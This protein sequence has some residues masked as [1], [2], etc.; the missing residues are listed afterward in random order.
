[1]TKTL[2]LNLLVAL[3]MLGCASAKTGDTAQAGNAA[4]NA[5]NPAGTFFSSHPS[6][7]EQSDCVSFLR[8]RYKP[9]HESTHKTNEA[10]RFWRDE[11]GF[12]K[13][14]TT[15][16]CMRF[17]Y[18]VGQVM[19]E[20]YVVKP[21]QAAQHPLPVIIYNRGGN[22]ALS[23]INSDTL[24]DDFF[25]LA[26]QGFIVIG[27][28]YRGALIWPANINFDPG[29]DEFGGEDV[30]DVTALIPILEKMPDADPKRIGM[31]GISRGGMMTYMASKNNPKIKAIV[32][33]A[34]VTDHI[35][36]IPFRPVFDQRLYPRLIPNYATNKEQVLRDRSVLFWLDEINIKM[37][38]L[39]LHGDADTKV[40]VTNSIKL[41]E[42][43]KHRGQPHKL[44]VYPKADHGLHPFQDQAM[45]EIVK[46][47]GTHL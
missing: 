41:A 21:K 44:I 23:T 2:L 1:M 7:T 39:L 3:C 14:A 6:I 4:D 43:L 40:S 16:D 34:G 27:S 45:T 12:A 37:P 19:V 38:I 11:V 42:K 26:K 36:E 22:P 46:W 15:V 9:P 10:M 8:A 28:Q 31:M 5:P 35:A 20:G 47:F 13:E 25:V 30:K 33:W 29:K 17:A 24:R 18:R 32:V